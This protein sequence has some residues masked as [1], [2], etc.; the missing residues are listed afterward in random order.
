[1]WEQNQLVV[2]VVVASDSHSLW[3]LGLQLEKNLK[4]M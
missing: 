4:L 2:Q 3:W 1:M